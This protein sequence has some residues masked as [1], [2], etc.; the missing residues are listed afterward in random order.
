MA[1]RPRDP[2]AAR[3]V[4]ERLLDVA[5]VPPPDPLPLLVHRLD[6]GTSGVVL[7]A[8]DGEVHRILSRAFQERRVEK[9]Y[10]GLV[11]GRPV[12]AVGRIDAPLGR[13]RT[14]ARRMRVDP[15]GSP[16]VTRFETL[17]RLPG[18]SDLRLL[19]ATGRTHQI[20]VHLASMGHPIVG[21]DLYGGATRWHG[22]RDGGIRR[23]ISLLRRPLLH[24]ARLTLAEEG[25]DVEAPLEDDHAALLS[26]LGGARPT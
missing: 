11:W 22:V 18:V 6:V 17:Q 10:R 13:D 15:T 19:P 1:T 8:R 21:D 16:A 14:D 26:L 12:P 25:I 3:R 20:R 24:G 7:L 9:E 4:V 5:G 23:A 2:G